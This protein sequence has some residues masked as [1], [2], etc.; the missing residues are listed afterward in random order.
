MNLSHPPAKLLRTRRAEN[1]PVASL[2]LPRS[3]RHDFWRLYSFARRGDDLADSPDLTPDQK[4]LG[5]KNLAAEIDSNHP[6]A[7]HF[8]QLIEAFEFDIDLDLGLVKISA[9]EDLLAYCRRSAVPVGRFLLGLHGIKSEAVIRA[10]DSLCC[11]LQILNHLQDLGADWRDLQRCYLPQ[12]WLAESGARQQDLTGLKLTPEWQGLVVMALGRCQLM[13]L[14]AQSLP[15]LLRDVGEVRLAA[16]ARMILR[17]A[18]DLALSLA[19]GD[20]LAGRIAPSKWDKCLAVGSGLGSLVRPRLRLGLGLGFW[21]SNFALPM[22]KLPRRQR[23]AVV[24]LYRF[25]RLLDDCADGDS[26]PDVKAARL[27]DWRLVMESFFASGS[28]GPLSECPRPLLDLRAVIAEFGLQQ[29]DLEA[30][31]DGMV[32]DIAPQQRLLSLAEVNL[33]CDQVASAVGR[34]FL[35]IIGIK[36]PKAGELAENL[37]RALQRVNILRDLAE[38]AARGRC[39]LPLESFPIGFA[40]KF[41]QRF[42]AGAILTAVESRIAI[43]SVASETSVYFRRAAQ[44]LVVME[45]KPVERQQIEIFARI[46]LRLLVR[47]LRQIRARDYGLTAHK[48]RLRGWDWLM[49]LVGR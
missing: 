45:L 8:N 29:S 10:S 25:C 3:I 36:N 33:Y 49:I 23:L 46:Y 20:P 44:T 1:V 38:D 34:L 41:N 30:I 19:R 2:L 26:L 28:I 7:V 22:V 6:E 21:R 27:A 48:T 43:E 12:D 40:E 11:L 15:K 35:T 31:F 9:W 42:D 47:V 13:I 32:F 17:L 37:G 16:E 39:T 24:A 5:L 4:R 18:V 14:S